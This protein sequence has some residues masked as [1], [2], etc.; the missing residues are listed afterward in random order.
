MTVRRQY[1]IVHW[2]MT[3]ILASVGPIGCAY[4][5][6]TGGVR[7]SPNGQ[8]VAFLWQ[9]FTAEPWLDGR[10]I[11]KNIYLLWSNAA[12]PSDLESVQIASLRGRHAS[13]YVRQWCFSPDSRSVAAVVPGSRQLVVVHLPSRQR[14]VLTREGE[15]VRSLA[16]LAPDEIGYAI[17][18]VT[19]EGKYV[20][21]FYRQRIRAPADQRVSILDILPPLSDEYWSPNGSRVLFVKDAE[22]QLTLLSVATGATRSV[23]PKNVLLRE[24]SWHPDGSQVFCVLQTKDNPNGIAALT[25]DADSG[26]VQDHSKG[27][28]SEFPRVLP[29]LQ[30][31]WAPEGGFVLANDRKKGAAIIRLQ[32]WGVVWVGEKARSRSG[33]P[34]GRG[35]PYM[36]RLPVPGWVVLVP[37]I[38]PPPSPLYATDYEGSDL[39]QLMQVPPWWAF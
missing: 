36:R 7:F 3:S 32:P 25:I 37:G 26:V 21:G 31:L 6:P 15:R 38:A 17:V 34:L 8:T 9:E 27:F 18:T 10:I 4:R 29:F 14:W 1:L 19:G 2:L 5:G 35:V 12:R 33:L 13:G 28:R 16:W 22:G 39:I 11:T 23:G 30:A 20:K 24:A